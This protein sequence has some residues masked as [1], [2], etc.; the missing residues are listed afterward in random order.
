[1]TPRAFAVTT[2]IATAAWLAPFL[3][4]CSA[5]ASF[6]TTGGTTTATAK[7]DTAGPDARIEH[8]P[9]T[10]ERPVHFA[11]VTHKRR[12]ATDF[13]RVA[14]YFTGKPENGSD[15]VVPSDSADRAGHWFTFG[16]GALETLPAGTVAILETVASDDPT[17]RSRTFALPAPDGRV[18]T[19]EYHLGLTGRD[20]PADGVKIVAWRLTLR[21]GERVVASEKSYLWELPAAK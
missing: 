3:A 17:P 5:S 6:G 1:M 13:K 20:A 19:R 7:V 10:D 21:A 16:I 15:I 2:A 18:V 8:R 9:A 4:G 11:Y 14:E 12:P